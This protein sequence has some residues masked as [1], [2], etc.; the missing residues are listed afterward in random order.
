MKTLI[1]NFSCILLLGLPA[2][3]L[4]LS[5]NAVDLYNVDEFEFA[6]IRTGMMPD[7]ALKK[8]AEYYSLNP[9]D[10][11]T[12]IIIGKVP[13]FDYENPVST[14][15]YSGDEGWIVL[16]LHP[17][18]L[19]DKETAHMVVEE[20]QI[21]MSRRYDSAERPK[22]RAA[23]IEAFSKKYGPPTLTIIN[24]EEP[25]KSEYYWCETKPTRKFA[26]NR[27]DSYAKFWFR[28]FE[29]SN[30]KITDAFSEARKARK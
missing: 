27:N 21:S 16:D 13:Y 4:S 1:K 5:A 14:Y 10:F 30:G 8:V 11:T 19:P 3:T 20:I 28:G 29:L 7:D 24:E 26:C 15:R 2:Y 12:N 23:V 18:L 17:E 25:F 22:M 9:D 6:G